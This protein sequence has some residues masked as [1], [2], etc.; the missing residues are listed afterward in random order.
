MTAP[1]TT[2]DAWWIF[3]WTRLDETTAASTNHSG[4]ERGRPVESSVAAMN[5]EVA[6][7]DGNELDRGRRRV[8]GRSCSHTGRVRRNSDFTPTL[9]S[10][11]STPSATDSR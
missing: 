6:W 7:P 11:D 1:A 9:I 4:R 5:P 10:A 8:R 2:S 3:T